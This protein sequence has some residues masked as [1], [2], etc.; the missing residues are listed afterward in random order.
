[1]VNAVTTSH[2]FIKK[3]KIIDHSLLTTYENSVFFINA[4]GESENKHRSIT[5]NRH[6]IP[7][8]TFNQT[9]KSAK[10]EL[11]LITFNKSK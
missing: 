6:R 1:M 11:D 10:N 9:Q 2:A 3:I 8:V 4:A 5:Q 7:S